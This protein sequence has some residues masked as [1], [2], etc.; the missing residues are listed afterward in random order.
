MQ[1]E[2]VTQEGYA[3][4]ILA[5]G[6]GRRLGGVD[7]VAVPVAGRPMLE[8][9]LTAVAD[10]ATRV[11]VGPPRDGLPADVLRVREEPPGGGPVAAAAAGLDVLPAAVSWVALL[12]GDLPYLTPEAVAL[13]RAAA[14]DPGLDGASTVDGAVLVDS[15]GRAQLLCGV[16]RA[17]ALRTRLA[18]LA[19]AGAGEVGA[20]LGRVG[21]VGAVGAGPGGVG[22]AA[23]GSGGLAGQSM[24]AL[25][26][27]LRVAEVIVPVAG[28]AP[29]PWYDC[30]TEDDLRRAEEWG[31]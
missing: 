12:A 31:R 13:L 21:A 24:R 7:K 6:A 19:G 15:E 14:A 29:P 18:A 8:R 1:T 4:V 25:L 27:G 26:A 22:A 10:A 11:V 28:S 30:D 20:G 16:W 2:R 17:G 3:A 9:V 23:A 5:G